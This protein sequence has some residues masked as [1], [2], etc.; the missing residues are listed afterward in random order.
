MVLHGLLLICL[1]THF[2]V[3]RAAIAPR[4][5]G[6]AALLNNVI[7]YYGGYTTINATDST[8]GGDTNDLLKLDLSTL[9]FSNLTFNWQQINPT[10]GALTY[11]GENLNVVAVNNRTQMV[12]H[13]WW[14]VTNSLTYQ[15]FNPVIGSPIT[16]NWQSI[17][18]PSDPSYQIP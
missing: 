13:G 7:Y 2:Y 3:T 12:V 8:T 1:C 11:G 18:F 16:N 4:G 15:V 6:G 14:T 5:G 10:P 9:D 17:N